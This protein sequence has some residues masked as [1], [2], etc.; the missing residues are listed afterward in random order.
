[1]YSPSAS[2]GSRSSQGGN[3]NLGFVLGTLLLLLVGLIVYIFNRPTQEYSLLKQL[4]PEPV[5]SAEDQRAAP[6]NKGNQINPNGE[7]L[8]DA[9]LSKPSEPAALK[10]EEEKKRKEEEKKARELAEQDK[11]AADATPDAPPLQ[12]AYADT[13]AKPAGATT[14]AQFTGTSEYAYTV[15]AGETLFRLASRF[16]NPATQIKAA[17]GLA[18]ENVAVGQQV[19]LKIQGIHKVGA[20]EGLNAIA[21]TYGISVQDIRKANELAGDQ[22]RLG[23]ELI[24]PVQ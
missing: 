9:V 17:S 10:P 20:G 16:R 8:L 19:K 24:I 2:S 7:K 23:Q 15:K 14:T 21:R 18:D 3:P 5:T 22:I 11:D 6:G 13:A 4:P 12:K 1:M